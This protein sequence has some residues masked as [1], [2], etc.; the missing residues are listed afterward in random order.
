MT[1]TLTQGLAGSRHDHGA[2]DLGPASVTRLATARL[3]TIYGEFDVTAYRDRGGKEHLLV[4]IG[5]HDGKPPI[6][7][8]HSECLTGDALGS[9]R[10]DCREQLHATLS[11]FGRERRGVLIYMR[12]EGRGIGL[13]Q[14][15]SRVRPARPGHGYGRGQSP[16]GLS[17]RRANVRKR[18]RDPS[19]SGNDGH[20]DPDQQPAQDRGA[21][22]SPDPDRRADSPHGPPRASESKVSG[23]K[24]RQAR[25]PARALALPWPRA[26]VSGIARVGNRSTRELETRDDLTMLTRKSIGDG[27]GRGL[28]PMSGRSSRARD[29]SRGQHSDRPYTTLAY[30]QSLDGSIAARPGQMLQL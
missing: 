17:G 26:A 8:L 30:A 6:V 20:P 7:R 28:F 2:D 13:A 29:A 4:Q 11:F 14:Q 12:Q 9:I 27:R 5:K 19:R 10:C 1:C 16:P 22:S 21:G 15:G 3:P 23:N 25:P 18:R 24:G